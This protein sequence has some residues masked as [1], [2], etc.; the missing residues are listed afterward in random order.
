MD[1]RGCAAFDPGSVADMGTTQAP[2][3]DVPT[4]TGLARLHLLAAAEPRAL[5]LLGHGAGGGVEAPDLATLTRAAVEAGITVGLVEQPYRVAGRRSPA[6]AARLDEAFITVSG[7]ASA[8]AAGR[9]LVVGGRSSGARVACR[10]AVR[11]GAVG[12]VALAF[13]LHPPGRP[14]RSRLTELAEVAAAGIPCLVVQGERDAFGS[15]AELAGQAPNGVR[16]LTAPGGDH[17][18]RRGLEAGQVTQWLDDLL[19]RAER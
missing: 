3:R 7:A 16:V 18:L 6:P 15:A 17:S 14:D 9:P 2:V 8:E 12:V 1:C 19:G 13:P 11:I 10:T 4:P 5:L